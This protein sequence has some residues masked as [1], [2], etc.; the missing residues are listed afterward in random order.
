MTRFFDMAAWER[1]YRADLPTASAELLHRPDLMGRRVIASISMA[2]RADFGGLEL[3]VLPIGDLPSIDDPFLRFGWYFVSEARAQ[4]VGQ[5]RAWDGQGLL[6]VV[7]GPISDGAAVL[8]VLRAIGAFFD[9]QK[10]VYD[11]FSCGWLG[12]CLGQGLYPT[13]AYASRVM[14][15]SL[16]M[17]ILS[18]L[19]ANRQI[20]HGDCP[21]MDWQMGNVVGEGHPH[22]G[23]ARHVFPRKAHADDRIDNP[24]ALLAGLGVACNLRNLVEPA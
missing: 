12:E 14:A 11:P 20:R 16:P 18:M 23:Q 3:L 19:I 9:L 15:F 22:V 2:S 24:V 5:Y 10:V 13:V 8:P 17:L 7:P 21:V 1:C 4:A 6:T